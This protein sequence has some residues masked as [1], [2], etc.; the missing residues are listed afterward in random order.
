MLINLSNHPSAKWGDEQMQAAT[1]Q[2]GRVV[3]IPF[4]QVDSNGDEGYI[5]SLAD[6]YVSR[7]I[8]AAADGFAT[9]HLMGEMTLTFALVCRLQ[10]LGYPCVAST[11]ERAVRELDDGSSEVRFKFV[12]FR[13]Y[14]SAS[15]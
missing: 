8:A 14:S 2:Y 3:D 6:E 13:T 9:V 10:R 12:Q 1:E 11:T 7:V 15:I 4:P 5:T